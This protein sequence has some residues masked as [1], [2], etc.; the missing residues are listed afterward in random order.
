MPKELSRNQ[1]FSYA[2]R[3][4]E[5][6]ETLLKQF[7]DIPTVSADPRHLA[8]IQKA[9]DLAVQTIRDFGGKATVY[10]TAGN[11]VLHGV[12]D[13][14]SD[15]PTITIYNHLDVQPA[16]RETEPWL[17]DPFV[18]ERKE[19]RYLGRGTTDDKGPALAAL[20]SAKAAFEF[21]IPVNI[22]LL[23]E[24]EEEIG[25]PHFED[26]LSAAADDI[27]TDMVIVS[28]TMW[29]SRQRPSIC[30][31]LRGVQGFRFR[32]ET[33]ATDQHSGDAGGPAR[34]PIGELMKMMC[35][36]HDPV[37]GKVKLPGFYV[38][39]I[40]P[41]KRETQDFLRSGFSV[42]RFKKNYRLKSLRTED[43]LEV[44][45]RIWAWPTFEIHGVVGGYTGPGI[46]AIVPPKAEV[47]ASCRLVP[48]QKPEKICRLIKAFVKSRNKDIQVYP[49]ASAVPYKGLTSGPLAEALKK[50]MKFAFGREPV[51]LRE[52]GSIGA[53]TSMQK[54]L[55]CPVMFLGLS[56]P[57][58]GYHAP[59]EN[60]DW[61]QASGGIAAFTKY[62]EQ[63]AL[64]GSGL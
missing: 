35:E 57:E 59:N 13:S 50:A 38:D 47:L 37:T 22:R 23:W 40:W 10:K 46:K 33:G 52:G 42:K 15:R 36:I 62:I 34:N 31:G 19:D 18:M 25:S 63:I 49:I 11:P 1:L 43:P 20:L 51:F 29:L 32:L 5:H 45:N 21:G 53:V 58:H 7:V 9:A 56:L 4:R 6:F 30:S 60:F 27:S 54:I 26:A 8:D 28:D 55:N 12:F 2:A 44:M 64:L 41:T 48:N 61:Q 3:E 39:V 16:S 17:T 14:G 24:F